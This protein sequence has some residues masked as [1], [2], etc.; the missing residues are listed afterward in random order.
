MRKYFR[1]SRGLKNKSQPKGSSISKCFAVAEKAYKYSDLYSL[2]NLI[3]TGILSIV[4]YSWYFTTIYLYGDAAKKILAILLT[5]I[6]FSCKESSVEPDFDNL[7]PTRD[8][9]LAMGN[10]SNAGTSDES[11]YLLDKPQ[12][13]VAYIRSKGTANW[14]SWHLSMAWKGT[15]VRKD[16]FK[17][18]DTLPSSW[19]KIKTTDYTNSGFDRGHL[20]PS[21]DRD[22]S[23]EDNDMTFLMTNIIPQSPSLNRG[24]WS[25]L[26]DYCRKVAAA[27]NELYIVAGVLDQGGSGSNGGTT[28]TLA[29]GKITV[30]A[31]VWKMIL[32]L[33]VGNN[34]VSRVNENSRVIAVNIPNKQS[35]TGGWGDYRLNVDDLEVLTGYDFLSNVPGEIQKVLER[36]KDSEPTVKVRLSR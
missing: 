35:L 16:D 11:N 21:D 2:A 26:E 23:Q 24:M 31:Y 20:C 18:D 22:F 6:V 5:L 13:V 29:D 30:P 34:D 15:A 9:H 28:K 4:P 12:F 19:Y 3:Y 25:A 33:P 7:N 27:G 17:P 8:A 36:R 1:T 10:P 32:I 14:V